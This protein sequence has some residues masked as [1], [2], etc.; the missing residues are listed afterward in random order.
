MAGVV[1]LTQPCQSLGNMTTIAKKKIEKHFFRK[2][3]GLLD[4]AVRQDVNTQ[5]QEYVVIVAIV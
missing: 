4:G 5:Y 1:V 2:L 3:Y